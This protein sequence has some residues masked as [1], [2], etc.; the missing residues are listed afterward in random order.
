M[1]ILAT[2]LLIMI[3]ASPVASEKALFQPEP[4]PMDCVRCGTAVPYIHFMTRGPFEDAKALRV[5]LSHLE[6]SEAVLIEVIEV[7]GRGGAL[8]VVEQYGLKFR[9][10]AEALPALRYNAGR[11]EKSPHYLSRV[12]WIG[13]RSFEVITEDEPLVFTALPEGG[14]EVEV[15]HVD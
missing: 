13:P 14:F 5:A 12:T 15:K 9:S 10:L 11:G 6:Q 7:L 4:V 8:R 2:F 3:S 1:I